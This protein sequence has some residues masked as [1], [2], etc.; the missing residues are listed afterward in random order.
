[1][2]PRD[3]SPRTLTGQKTLTFS[4][5][6]SPRVL[7][8]RC[9]PSETVAR[10]ASLTVQPKRSFIALNADRGTFNP[11]PVRWGPILRLKKRSGRGVTILRPTF[12]SPAHGTRVV[13]QM[14]GTLE[15]SGFAA[16]LK[17]HNI[18]RMSC[19]LV[20]SGRGFHSSAGGSGLKPSG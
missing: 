6:D 1:M 5:T 10:T 4:G 15:R 9:N 13:F 8:H 14:A 18:G 17:F 3:S 19:Q 7:N 12:N 11:R 16:A 20:G 2:R